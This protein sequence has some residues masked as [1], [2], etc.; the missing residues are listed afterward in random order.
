M[1][2]EKELKKASVNDYRVYSKLA[3]ARRILE[4][5]K[6]E[7]AKNP[8]GHNHDGTKWSDIS[9]TIDELTEQLHE[10]ERKLWR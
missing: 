9:K 7:L 2:W 6:I 4:K 1:K 3:D 10:L 5:C 8:D